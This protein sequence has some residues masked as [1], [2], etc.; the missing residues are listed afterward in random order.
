ML[1]IPATVLRWNG[2]SARDTAGGVRSNTQSPLLLPHVNGQYVKRVSFQ[3]IVEVVVRV[4][5]CHD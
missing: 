1:Q 3:I 5:L 2:V 4:Y